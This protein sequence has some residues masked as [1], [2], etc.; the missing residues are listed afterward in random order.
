MT[1]KFLNPLLLKIANNVFSSTQNVL[2]VLLFGKFVVI[3]V[4][5]NRF[6][7]PVDTGRKLNVHK[8]LCTFN[9]RPVPAGKI[10]LTNSVAFLLQKMLQ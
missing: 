10:V 5:S 9:L 6:P 2:Q 3:M 8:N 1:L 4:S 7:N